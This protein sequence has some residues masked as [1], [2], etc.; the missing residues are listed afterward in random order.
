MRHT[1]HPK[2]KVEST[3]GIDTLALIVSIIRP[4]TTLPQIYIVFAEQNASQ[5]SLFMWTGYNVASV[6][7][8]IYGFKHKLLPVICAQILWIVVQ[9]A[10]M[11][12][13]FLF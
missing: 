9:T 10:M 3:G 12:A 7:L 13:V 5:I 6:I 8:L 11:I 2:H 4:L 1:L